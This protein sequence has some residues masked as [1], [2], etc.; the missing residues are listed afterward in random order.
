MAVSIQRRDGLDLTFFESV[1]YVLFNSSCKI[2]VEIFFSGWNTSSGSPLKPD[3]LVIPK[4]D[5]ISTSPTYNILGVT[6]WRERH[7]GA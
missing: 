1:L 5:P 3:I 2:K 4:A 6:L 7:Q